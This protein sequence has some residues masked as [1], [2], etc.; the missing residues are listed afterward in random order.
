M[1]LPRHVRAPIRSILVD[2]DSTLH[3]MGEQFA[4]F[5]R[6]DHG[7]E[8]APERID[9]WDLTE[10]GISDDDVRALIAR[11]HA[12]EEIEAA[13]PYPGSVETLRRWA[14]AGVR[15]H[16]VSDR[17]S[18]TEGATR[19]WLERIGVPLAALAIGPGIDKLD[20]IRR[21]RLDLA[22]DDK[23]AFLETLVAAGVPSAT[24]IHPYNR[25]QVANY[26]SIIAATDWAG[27]AG[28]LE[29]RFVFGEAPGPRVV[30][31]LG[32]PGAGKGT[33]AQELERDGWIHLS[34]G[35]AMREWSRGSRPEQVALAE[36]LAR[37]EYGSDELAV[38]IIE[39]FL[40]GPGAHSPVIL[41]DGFPRTATQLDVWLARPG[42]PGALLSLEL[43][44]GA[45]R[46]RIARRRQ[47]PL[48]G[49]TGNTG[50]ERCA[51]CGGELV[52]R[53]EDRGEPVARRMREYELRVA[54]LVERWAATGLPMCRIDAAKPIERR[55]AEARS[56]VRSLSPAAPAE[57]PQ[58]PVG[59]ADPAIAARD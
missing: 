54:P 14:A 29:R 37:G 3:P 35:Q 12:D 10:L 1:E 13:I 16:I 41:L 8:I 40:A 19:R 5:L 34:V 46:R 15:I 53:P 48:D 32:R 33:I 18:R 44:E 58:G 55:L 56:F 39:E 36:S 38:T 7:I 51:R 43:G 45:A 50:H 23:P 49:W 24:L 59:P 28:D 21:Q 2:I 4:R 27:L 31:L 11:C 47:C 42:A 25:R 30:L 22:I 26:S 52:P 57:A 17:A 9:S 20:Y 6:S